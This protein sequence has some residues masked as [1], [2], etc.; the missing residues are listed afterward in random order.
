MEQTHDTRQPAFT[1]DSP[2]A[3]P[4]PPVPPVYTRR[5]LPLKSAPFAVILSVLMP[6]LGYVY[7]GYFRQAVTTVVIFASLITALASGAADGI[8]PLFGIFLAFFYFYQLVDAGRRATMFN[9]ALEAGYAGGVPADFALP[10]A[11]GMLFG[12]MV[13]LAIGVV[14]LLNTVLDVELEWLKDW[15]PVGLIIAGGWLVARSRREKRPRQ[16]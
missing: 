16:V 3:P 8:E 4:P 2:H 15:W 12:G 13:L 11:G 14:A 9:Q 6:G 1:P 5:D 10:D 7:L